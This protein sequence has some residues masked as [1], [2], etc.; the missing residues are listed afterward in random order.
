VRPAWSATVVAFN[1]TQGGFEDAAGLMMP[2]VPIEGGSLTVTAG[3]PIPG[4]EWQV[5]AFRYNDRRR[6]F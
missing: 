4:T 6:V 3:R 1:A 2:D 5:F